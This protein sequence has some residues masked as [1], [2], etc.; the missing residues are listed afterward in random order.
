MTQVQG[1]SIL[2]SQANYTQSRSKCCCC[3]GTPAGK[4]PPQGQ[5]WA[6]HANWTG[7]GRGHVPDAVGKRLNVQQVLAGEFRLIRNEGKARL[8]LGAHQTFD[9]IGGALAVIG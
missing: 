1:A 3:P 2:E 9:R 4:R 8:G 6:R 7:R 5:F